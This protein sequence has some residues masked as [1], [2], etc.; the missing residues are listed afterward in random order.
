MYVWLSPE[1]K[2]KMFKILDGLRIN[3]VLVEI[4]NKL[5]FVHVVYGEWEMKLKTINGK[6]YKVR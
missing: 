6:I 3:G 5:T 1:K 4:K 2:E